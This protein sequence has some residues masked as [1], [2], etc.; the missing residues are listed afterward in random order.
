MRHQVFFCLSIFN[1][2]TPQ[3]S[4]E[5]NESSFA[6]GRIYPQTESKTKSI[7]GGFGSL[8]PNYAPTLGLEGGLL[9]DSSSTLSDNLR[10]SFESRMSQDMVFLT[11]L[12]GASFSQNLNKRRRSSQMMGEPGLWAKIPRSDAELEDVDHSKS[13]PQ[14][15][16]ATSLSKV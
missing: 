2:T 10:Y 1:A 13:S 14:T 11:E 8:Y 15:T 9:Y 12:G 4:S 5:A 7:T 3:A 16:E 6:F